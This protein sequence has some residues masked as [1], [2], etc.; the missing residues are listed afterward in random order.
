MIGTRGTRLRTLLLSIALVVGATTATH[1][2]AAA[3]TAAPTQHEQALKLFEQG[4]AAYKE[5]RF[6]DSVD[7]LKKAY[8][9]EKEPLLLYNLARAYEGLGDFENAL[10][11]YESYLST[12]KDV[13]DRGAIEQRIATLKSTIADREKLARERDEAQA[14]AAAS[15]ANNQAAASKP[16]ETASPSPIPW[17]IA[18]VGVAGIGVGAGLGAVALSKD[19]DAQTASSQRDA[20]DLHDSA[21]GLALGSTIAFIAGGVIAAGGTTW[22]II[23]IAT[24]GPATSD[25][26]KTAPAAALRV[27]PTSVSF[28]LRF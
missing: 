18:G 26:A 7:L 17:I 22:G 20:V 23:D 5:G 14:R 13:P 2:A 9:L 12:A 10:A 6:Q 21:T 15:A 4:G 25:D 3:P 1:S 19:S 28:D 8:E 27:G 24:L 11:T 16:V